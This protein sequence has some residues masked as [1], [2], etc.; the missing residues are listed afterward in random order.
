V[1]TIADFENESDEMRKMGQDLTPEMWL[2]KL[3]LGAID[4]SYDSKDEANAP[5]VMSGGLG[6][7][8]PG[9]YP[10]QQGGPGGP[11]GYPGQSQY[12]G[13]PQ[14]GYAPPPGGPPQ[15]QPGYG[16]PQQGGYGRGYPPPAQGGPRY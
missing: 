7:G 6:R 14:G 4:R 16:Q 12:G 13:P 1:L 15:G 9:G 10:G 3:M 2:V 8:G 11:G 5:P